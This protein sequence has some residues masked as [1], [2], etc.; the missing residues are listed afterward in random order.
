VEV[1]DDRELVERAKH[2]PEAFGCLYDRYVTTVYRYVLGRVKNQF[3]AEDLTAEVFHRALKSIVHFRWQ[4]ITFSAWL[5]GIARRTVADHFRRTG[6]EVVRGLPEHLHASDADHEFS[7]PDLWRA[8]DELPAP[9]RQVVLLRFCGDFTFRQISRVM[10][11]SEDA[12]KM[13]LYRALKKLRKVVEM[14]DRAE[15]GR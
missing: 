8:V 14:D 12:V 15:E 10:G 11:K 3:L 6:R 1:L 4:G 9:Q 13:L 5:F 7:D 2:D